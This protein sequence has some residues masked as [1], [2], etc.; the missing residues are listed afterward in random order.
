MKTDTPAK[1]YQTGNPHPTEKLLAF[2][3][4]CDQGHEIWTSVFGDTEAPYRLAKLNGQYPPCYKCK[5][6]HT[7]GTEVAPNHPKKLPQSPPVDSPG[8]N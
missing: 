2:V 7:S 6:L 5:R 3:G 1:K 8:T 4:Y